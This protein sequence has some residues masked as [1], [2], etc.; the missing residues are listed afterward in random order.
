MA[1]TATPVFI[2]APK[3][4]MVQIVPADTTANKTVVTA[5]SNGTKVFSLY[6]YSDDT[7]TV[8]LRV[9]IV[10]SATTYPITTVNI[11]LSAG[12]TSAIPPV[13]MLA[14]PQFPS[15]MLAKDAD[16][17]QY[18]FLVSGDTLVVNALVTVTAAK[19]VTVHSDHGDF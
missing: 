17:Q 10:R 12:L 1:V 4:S 11:P 2:Q 15:G 5:G 9:S 3:H 8:N 6:C 16:G 13:N 7:A 18:L 19:T 14:T